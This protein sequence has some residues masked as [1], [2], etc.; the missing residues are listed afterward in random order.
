M[1]G[2]E[3][4]KSGFHDLLSSSVNEGKDYDLILS[5]YNH[6]LGFE[7]KAVLRALIANRDAQRGSLE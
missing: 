6:Q 7:G 4:S 5:E 1:F 2:L 3:V